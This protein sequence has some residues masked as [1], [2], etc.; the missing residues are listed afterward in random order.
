MPGSESC[1]SRPHG[2]LRLMQLRLLFLD[3]PPGGALLHQRGDPHV[4]WALVVSNHRPPPCKGANAESTDLRRW[5][6]TA[7]EQASECSTLLIVSQRFAFA[8][9]TNAGQPENHGGRRRRVTPALPRSR[10]DNKGAPRSASACYVTAR[11]RDPLRSS[12]PVCGRELAGGF[13]SRPPPLRP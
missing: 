2:D 8:R 13:D 7:S 12:K 3:L 5:P 10:T 4:S 11:S 6:N 9:G 1:A